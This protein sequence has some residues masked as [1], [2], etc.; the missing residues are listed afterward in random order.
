MLFRQLLGVKTKKYPV[1]ERGLL[2]KLNNNFWITLK[3]SRKIAHTHNT[4]E[5][6]VFY[7]KNYMIIFIVQL[8]CYPYFHFTQKHIETSLIG[9]SHDALS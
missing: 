9:K 1:H 7:K 2:F 6:E 5:L 8:R 4:V 3:K